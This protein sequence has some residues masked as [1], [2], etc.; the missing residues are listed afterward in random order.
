MVKVQIGIPTYR[1]N[2]TT[3]VL[4]LDALTRQTY[5]DFEILVVYKPS[6]DDIRTLDVIEKFSKRL[7]IKVIEQKYGKI[8]E[9]MNLIYS[10]ATADILLTL[11]DDNIPT[12]K[13]IED[14]LK[15]HEK[16]P[17]AGAFRGKIKHKGD[18][19]IT[20]DAKIRSLIKRI[21]YRPYSHEFREYAGYL[22]IFG[23]PTDR[24]VKRMGEIVKTITLAGE[25]MS[26]KREVGPPK[27]SERAKEW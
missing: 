22:T 6:E 19:S 26:I 27:R 12:E 25:N 7:D 18:V 13:W 14:H 17:E 16:Y 2:G 15:F 8:E 10:N 1:N 5:K 23:V 24:R 11:D 3:I 20:L 21:F 4:V 9:A